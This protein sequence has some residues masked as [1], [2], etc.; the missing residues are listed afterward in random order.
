[1][2]WLVALLPGAL[3][4]ILGPRTGA[5]AE[6]SSAEGVVTPEALVREVYARHER[7]VTASGTPLT[8]EISNVRVIP[9]S[10]FGGVRLREVVTL[11]P[12]HSVAVDVSTFAFSGK[13]VGISFPAHWIENGDQPEGAADFDPTLE[14]ASQLE[15]QELGRQVPVPDAIVAFDARITLE[16]RTVS[17]KANFVLPEYRPGEPIREFRFNDRVLIIAPE[18]L[19][20]PRTARPEAELREVT[21]PPDG[22]GE[23]TRD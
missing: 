3:P 4:G 19:V 12:K 23:S 11:W 13:N 7:Q 9:A 14:E 20:E 10:E 1:V 18:L 16:S 5:L 2:L 22:R 8:I 6:E 17:Y 15:A 21:L